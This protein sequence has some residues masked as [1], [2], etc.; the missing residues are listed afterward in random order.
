MQNDRHKLSSKDKK[1][2]Q[3]LF[4]FVEPVKKFLRFSQKFQISGQKFYF[5][6]FFCLE[7]HEFVVSKYSL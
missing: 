5:S 6:K 4:F 2:R 3:Q 1:F 7:N